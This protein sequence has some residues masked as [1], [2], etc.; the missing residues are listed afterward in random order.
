MSRMIFRSTT[1]TVR[2]L[3][4]R[5]LELLRLNTLQILDEGVLLYEKVS[6]LGN[7][8]SYVIDRGATTHFI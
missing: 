4:N 5:C 1:Y 8:E 7:C 2:C 6:E 3:A